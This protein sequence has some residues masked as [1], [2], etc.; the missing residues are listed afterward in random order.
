MC[1]ISMGETSENVAERYGIT[2]E[3]QDQM[4]YES[5]L[6]AARAQKEGRF[7][8][9]II[10]VT[11]TIVNAEGKSQTITVN[12]DDGIRASTLETLAK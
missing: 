7:N 10:P 4:A 12:Q 3:E 5:Q 8:Q 1:L 11:T 6:K 2:R 9:E